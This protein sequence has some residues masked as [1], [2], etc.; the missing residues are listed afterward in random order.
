[1]SRETSKK[2]FSNLSI[3]TR[4]WV[5]SLDICEI[6][7]KRLSHRAQH[8]LLELWKTLSWAQKEVEMRQKKVTAYSCLHLQRCTRQFHSGP[9]QQGHP[10][11][12]TL[13]LSGSDH[14]YW[15][16]RRKPLT[17]HRNPSSFSCYRVLQFPSQGTPDPSEPLFPQ[18]IM[19]LKVQILN[20]PWCPA[21]SMKRWAGTLQVRCRQALILTDLP[22][23]C[24]AV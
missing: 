3:Q 2:S 20:Y 1:M 15:K 6:D 17:S 5:N 9:R 24:C 8:V 12:R 11:V 18:K 19:S 16:L 4:Y 13:Y 22:E 23:K 14:W 21:D 7:N 10:G